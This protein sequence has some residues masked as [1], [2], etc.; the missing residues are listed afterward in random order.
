ML[1]KIRTMLIIKKKNKTMKNINPDNF[2]TV[3]KTIEDF[4]LST[5]PMYD[6]KEYQTENAQRYLN[7]YNDYKPTYNSPKWVRRLNFRIESLYV[8]YMSKYYS[9]KDR[10]DRDKIIS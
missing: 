4:D 6:N 1:N 7:T 5:D 8:N 2:P 9:W 10:R 3:D